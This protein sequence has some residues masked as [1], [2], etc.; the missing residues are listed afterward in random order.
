MWLNLLAARGGGRS[1]SQFNGVGEVD[2]GVD[3]DDDDGD[4]HQR[5]AHDKQEE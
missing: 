1:N 2:A 4:Q 3:G 5:L